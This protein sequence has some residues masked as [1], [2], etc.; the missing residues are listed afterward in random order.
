MIGRRATGSRPV[1]RAGGNLDE[2]TA[3]SEEAAH[4]AALLLLESRA[5]TR[6]ELEQ[7][8]SRRGFATDAIER[9][10]DRLTA[11]GLV[12]DETFARELASSRVEQ[13]VDAPRIVVELKDR[14]VDPDLAARIAGESAPHTDRAE[15]CRE[16]AEARF[17][18]L[19]G[20]RPEVQYRRLAAYLVRR[21]YPGEIVEPVVSEL[22]DSSSYAESEAEEEYGQL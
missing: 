15:R 1:R 10:L 19:R 13:G 9:A 18:K 3:A 12:D 4:S 20:L 5:R 17:A 11:V 14:G 2:K 16:L 7:R 21:G 22:V 8:L 6:L